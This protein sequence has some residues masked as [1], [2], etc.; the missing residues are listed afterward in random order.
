[1]MLAQ[2]ITVMAL[3]L[4]VAVAPVLALLMWCLQ[5][6]PSLSQIIHAARR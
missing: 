2:S 6:T 3:A 4:L 1:M 5:P